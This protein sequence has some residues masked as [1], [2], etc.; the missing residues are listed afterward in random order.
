MSE[1]SAVARFTDAPHPRGRGSVAEAAGAAWLERHGYRILVRNYGPRWAEIDV[2]AREGDTLCFIEIKARR[3]EDLG[4]PLE[5]VTSQKQSQIVRAATHYLVETDWPGPCRF[6]VL[7]M[8]ADAGGDWR[9]ELIRDA[10][11][12]PQR[13]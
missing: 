9:F 13:A 12:V 8:T 6:D 4:S 1:D 7:G 11:E 2:V 10:F 3:N 5:A